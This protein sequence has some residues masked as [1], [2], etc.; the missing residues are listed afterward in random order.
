MDTATKPGGLNSTPQNPTSG[1]SASS[2]T[3]FIKRKGEKQLKIGGYFGFKVKSG[4]LPCE[5]EAKGL[6]RAVEHWD[7]YIRENENPTTC[8]V[9]NNVTHNYLSL[10]KEMG[11]CKCSYSY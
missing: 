2:A 9:D 7:H 3:L 8:L 10:Y 1:D 4:M 11:L 6:E 5:A